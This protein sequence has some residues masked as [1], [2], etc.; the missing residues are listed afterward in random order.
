MLLGKGG[1]QGTQLGSGPWTKPCE[2]LIIPGELVLVAACS[3][4]ALDMCCGCLW[5]AFP[6]H[7]SLVGEAV[8]ITPELSIR[9]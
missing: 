4:E 7:P 2:C 3:L 9:E 6:F 1:W 8:Q 5:V